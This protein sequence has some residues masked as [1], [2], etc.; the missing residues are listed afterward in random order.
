MKFVCEQCGSKYAI[1]DQKVA[2]K[3][4]KIKCKKCDNIITVRDPRKRVSKPPPQ[5]L[6]SKSPD[7]ESLLRPSSPPPARKKKLPPLENRQIPPLAPA[8]PSKPGDDSDT[9]EDGKLPGAAADGEISESCWFVGMD[10]VPRG[11]VSAVKI[12]SLKRAGKIDGESLVWKEGMTDWTPLAE[13]EELSEL[14]G[15]IEEM[16]A[17][18]RPGMIEDLP[19]PSAAASADNPEQP[20]LQGRASGRQLGGPDAEDQPAKSF[21]EEPSD[22]LRAEPGQAIEEKSHGAPAAV[23]IEIEGG[24][25]TLRSLVPPKPPGGINNR[26][27]LMAA[28]GFFA[29][30]LVTLGVALFGGGDSDKAN[31][32][33]KT[34][35]RVIEKVVYLDRPAEG[36]EL[37]SITDRPPRLEKGEAVESAADEKPLKVGKG[38]SKQPANKSKEPDSKTKELMERMGVSAPSGSGLGGGSSSKQSGE[39]NSGVGALTANQVKAVVD[40][41]KRELKSCYERALKQGEAPDDRDIRVDFKVTVGSSGTVKRVDVSGEGARIASLSGCLERSVSRWV[42]PQSSQDSPVEFPFVFSPR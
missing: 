13:V 17:A 18:S 26:V 7:S 10:N 6:E 12:R 37:L 14:L 38:G 36:S 16:S 31:T 24:V 23:N 19:P 4:L 39:K 25:G 15:R 42:F 35:E 32:S 8:S 28:I 1:S 22:G 9:V 33:A 27:I 5:D 41:N 20:D 21:F 30:S 2:N 3:T 11:P 34:V 29:V 40:R